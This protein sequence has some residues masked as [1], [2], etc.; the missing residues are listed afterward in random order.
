MRTF[1]YIWL[2]L[3][4]CVASATAQEFTARVSKSALGV[5]EQFKIEYRLEGKGSRFSP[6][7]FDPFVIVAGPNTSRSMQWINGKTSTTESY[8]YILQATREGEF[9]IGPASI[10]VDGQVVESNA[11]SIKVTKGSPQNRQHP[12]PPPG[13][14]NRPD[15]GPP[16]KGDLNSQI[17][18]KLFVTK[19]KT[20]V[21]EQFLAT[22]K[23]YSAL[24]IVGIESMNRP[25]YNGFYTKELETD[26]QSTHQIER[27]NNR[28]FDVYTLKQVL[29]T[30]QKTGKLEIP[31]V[32]LSLIISVP[33]PNR[34]RTIFDAFFGGSTRKRVKVNSNSEYVEV[35]AL[36]RANQPKDF[37]GA[38]GQFNISASV[39]RAAVFVN[40]A[41]TLKV[42]IEGRGNLELLTPP[43]IEFPSDFEVY[44]PRLIEQIKSEPGGTRGRI[45][46]EYVIIPR[47]AGE[48]EIPRISFSYYDPENDRYKSLSTAPIAITVAP[49]T[50]GSGNASATYA[51]PRKNSVQML[52]ND[53][54]YIKTSAPKLREHAEPIFGTA[55]F[56]A[57]CVLPIAITGIA[58][59]LIGLVRKHNEDQTEVRRRRARRMARKHLSRARKLLKQDQKAFYEELSKAL[60]GYLS[61]K[62][63]LPASELSRDRIR[64]KLIEKNVSESKI[65]NLISTLDECDMARFAPS[66]VRDPENML[67]HT[68]ELIQSIEDE[69]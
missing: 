28:P 63:A 58:M 11:V 8:S 46:Y 6:P 20:V 39:D 37:T 38:V 26:V 30:P 53:I 68:S 10:V 65:N 57:L 66:S 36:P 48:F 67:K 14:R 22:Y 47:Y 62:L 42:S 59:L 19:K 18:V 32:E 25:V 44:D 3:H 64:E 52:G 13:R 54:R 5:G 43:A 45:I 35:D 60:F 21:G 4:C 12:A 33:T 15:E 51:R 27:I 61:D 55:L 69:A 50:D 17:F 24:N 49:G 9:E 56:Y 31:P 29:L 2:I 34:G 40:E 1:A 7:P 41:V 23:L 16:A